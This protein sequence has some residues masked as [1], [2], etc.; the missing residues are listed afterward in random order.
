MS[1][2]NRLIVG[3]LWAFL[4]QGTTLLF[5]LLSTVLLARLLDSSDLGL[6][7]MASSIVVL[8][9]AVAQLGLGKAASR[10]I[11]RSISMNT[12]DEA[13]GYVLSISLLAVTSTVTISVLLAVWG[14][15]FLALKLFTSEDL[16]S[17]KYMVILWMALFALRNVMLDIYRGFHDIRSTVILGEPL[18]KT[19]FAFSLL[20]VWILNCNISLQNT[21]LILATSITAALVVGSVRLAIRSRQYVRV[22]FSPIIPLLRVALPLLV[23]N[24]TNMAYGQAN[25]WLVSAFRPDKDVA[26]FGAAMRLAIFV[27]LPLVV[28]SS[29]MPPII[30]ALFAHNDRKRLSSVLQLTAS[31][32]AIPASLLTVVLLLFGKEILGLLY[33]AFYID[34]Y[35]ILSV[36][37]IGYFITVVAG[38]AGLSLSMTAHQEVTMWVN[39]AGL[40]TLVIGGIIAGPLY[41]ALG[42]A[43]VS[44]CVVS[45]IAISCAVLCRHVLAIDTFAKFSSLRGG[46]LRYLIDKV[47]DRLVGSNKE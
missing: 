35:P 36:L 10:E 45:I 32:A 39:T 19:L 22:T 42:I 6:F 21:I 16:L 15:H 17:I 24:V 23:V 27:S 30:A 3:S 12:I 20:G 8:I 7:F 25:V 38:L 33:G 46:D 29:I 14:Y 13:W 31:L 11:G 4:G 2:K 47:Y 1:L 18:T 37:C 40:I 26:L 44:T 9:S 34:A 41:G 43:I 28:I 5:G